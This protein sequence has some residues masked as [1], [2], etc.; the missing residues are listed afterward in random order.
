VKLDFGCGPNPRQ[1]FEGVDIRDF[2]QKWKVDLA[3]RVPL[4]YDGQ[5]ATGW[6]GM[7]VSFKPWP[8]ADNSIDE[9]HCSHFL[10]HLTAPERIHFVNELYRVLLPGAVCHLTVPNWASA[11]AYGDLTHQWPPVSGFW[12]S[13]L[14]KEWRKGYAPH[15]DAYTCD[16]RVSWGYS[17]HDSLKKKKKKKVLKALTFH[18]EAGQDII[19][20]LQKV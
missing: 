20:D 10:E 14:N 19:A 7:P 18:I 8:W 2:G 5:T 3:E 1:G 15:N 17:L 6:A 13:Y 9:A 12:F 11:R 4:V 16:F